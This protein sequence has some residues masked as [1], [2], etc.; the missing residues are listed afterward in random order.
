MKK[1]VTAMT[2]MIV[3][4]VIVFSVYTVAFF[5]D[6]AGQGKVITIAGGNVSGEL[7]EVTIPEP[8]AQPVYGPTEMRIRPGAAVEKSV[9]VENT[10]TLAMY[11]RVTVDK[12]IVL[13]EANEG[14]DVDT[15]LVSFNLNATY[16]EEREGFYYYRE[17]LMPDQTT[18]PLFTTVSFAPEMGNTYTNSTIT[19][20]VKAYATQVSD[21]G[22]SVFEVQHWPAV[23]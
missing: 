11:L 14:S 19:L 10:G 18:E 21:N 7:I 5:S 2:A 4:A 13:S 16:W 1:F 6:S 15:S 23:Q 22:A 20:D 9:S 17:P 8:G 3:T 12:K